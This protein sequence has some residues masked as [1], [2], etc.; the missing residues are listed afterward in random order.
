MLFMCILYSMTVL[1]GRDSTLV[2]VSL[3]LVVTS[4]SDAVLFHSDNMS[5]Y[6]MF[7]I[8]EHCIRVCYDLMLVSRVDVP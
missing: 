5:S 7:T 2:S 4:L 3:I 1:G 6:K 8:G